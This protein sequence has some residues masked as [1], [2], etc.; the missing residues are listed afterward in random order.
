MSS[1]PSLVWD[2]C[3]VITLLKEGLDPFLKGQTVL[4]VQSKELRYVP[5]DVLAQTQTLEVGDGRVDDLLVG[6]SLKGPTVVTLDRRLIRRIR[7]RG[8][9]VIHYRMVRDHLLGRGY[10]HWI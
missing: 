2:T 4:T 10:N 7:A 9:R 6:V 8:G 3:A 1:T 5:R